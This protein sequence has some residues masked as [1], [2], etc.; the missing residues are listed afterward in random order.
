MTQPGQSDIDKGAGLLL[1][2]LTW[3]GGF[4]NDEAVRSLRSAKLDAAVVV[5]AQV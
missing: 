4:G 3:R 1:Y 5:T 2:L